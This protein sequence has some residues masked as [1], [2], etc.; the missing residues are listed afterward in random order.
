MKE[1]IT[2]EK[3]E[4]KSK[5]DRLINMYVVLQTAD[6]N[7]FGGTAGTIYDLNFFYFLLSVL[8]SL[9]LLFFNSGI[10]K[11]GS[12]DVVTAVCVQWDI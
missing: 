2:K 9:L 6:P 3:E 7:R 4:N 12:E 5:I 8:L 10:H 11:N 1:L